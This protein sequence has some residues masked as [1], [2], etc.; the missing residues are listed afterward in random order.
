MLNKE[1]NKE[2]AELL[3]EIA[4][5][6]ELNDFINDVDCFIKNNEAYKAHI[7]M[8][9]GYN[10]GKSALLNR[11]IG[12]EVLSEAQKPETDI[13]TELYFSENE[14]IVANLGDGSKKNVSSLEDIDIANCLNA[15]CYVNSENIKIQ[16]DYILVD[17]PGTD[18]GI[19]KHNKALMQYIDRATV[20]FLVVD[21]EKGTISESTL[22]FV[23]EIS[24]YSNDIAV[25]LNKCD[26]VVSSEVEKVKEHIEELMYVTTGKNYP[27]VCTSIHDEDV[28][29]KIKE[30]VKSFSP[31]YL[32]KKYITSILEDKCDVLID[33]LE[34]IKKNASCDTEEIEIEIRKREKAREE[35]LRQIERE[36]R[37]LSKKV[38]IEMKESIMARINT[39]LEAN[40]ISIAEA[41]KGGIENFKERILGIVRPIMIDEIES[42]SL[43]ACE[44]FIQNLNIKSFEEKDNYDEIKSVVETV[45]GKLKDMSEKGTLLVENKLNEN[46]Q[47][48]EKNKSGKNAYRVMSSIL[49]ITTSAI[50]PV[51]ELLIVFL[52]D[53]LRLINSLIGNTKEQ[54]LIDE[55]KYKIIPNIVS[56]LRTDIDTSLLEVEE[57][58]VENITKNI[59]DILTIENNALE[60]AIKKKNDLEANYSEFILTIDND[61]EKI[62]K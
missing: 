24:G 2:R 42:Y 52:P 22:N 45:Y 6:Y 37:R 21:C 35:L 3:K 15:E 26:K 59:E 43:T 14:R 23:S 34:L 60:V 11:Y 18:S 30:L 46:S 41:Y 44:G 36:K 13:A 19:E 31:E 25:I 33:A 38:R 58:M 61:I 8:I 54:Q 40:V 50:S 55:I 1:K 49:A 47:D 20:F 12:K 16:S 62:R 10:A 27:I 29:E 53:I 17:T 7:V 57:T 51:L 5:K 39:E 4:N 9:G 28:D 48:G 32:Y 56:K